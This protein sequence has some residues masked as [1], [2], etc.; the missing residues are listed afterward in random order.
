M[1]F[2]RDVNSLRCFTTYGL[3]E[4]YEPFQVNM[5]RDITLWYNKDMPVSEPTSV[6]D[7]FM[8]RRSLSFRPPYMSHPRRSPTCTRRGLKWM[9][10]Q[11]RSTRGSPALLF[12][13]L[14]SAGHPPAT[15]SQS[16][17]EAQCSR[18]QS[19]LGNSPATTRVCVRFR[20]HAAPL[21]V[22]S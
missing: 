1:N 5:T 16:C 6:V 18:P 3:Q 22:S 17:S 14:V 20:K 9:Y 15:G 7:L 4:G 10:K 13:S 12:Q 8:L 19:T 21:S 2:G 11:A